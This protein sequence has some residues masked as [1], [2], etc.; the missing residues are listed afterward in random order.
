MFRIFV[1]ASLVLITCTI[2][3]QVV[4]R[5]LF[6]APPAWTDEVAL[7]IM[8]YV[9]VVGSGWGIRDS[10]HIFVELVVSKL[11]KKARLGTEILAT[12][13]TLI[14]LSCML[15]YGIELCQLTYRQT[16]PATKMSVA[17]V[18]LP[19]PTRES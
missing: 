18:C 10:I 13:I 4:M 16:L 15:Y 11:P 9:A 1:I 19:M 6:N 17:C 14:F 2:F 12:S 5:D 8:I 3:Y 7:V